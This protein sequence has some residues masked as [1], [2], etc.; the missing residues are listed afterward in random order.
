MKVEGR[1]FMQ[2]PDPEFYSSD[3]IA[4][5]SLFA[6]APT[7]SSH[8]PAL[9][10]E[11]KWTRRALLLGSGALLGG[12]GMGMGYAVSS[13]LVVNPFA[14]PPVATAPPVATTAQ[15]GHGQNAL[16]TM[17][18]LQTTFTRHEQLVRAV[19]WSPGGALL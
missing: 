10:K 19:A 12:L 15:P 2:K 1:K 11:R 18:R 14:V 6:P 16:P 13:S 7:T 17:A 3:T 5:A 9:K 4:D 8:L